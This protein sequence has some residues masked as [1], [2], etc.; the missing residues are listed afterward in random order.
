MLR[1]SG[2][3]DM[4]TF[5]DLIFTR[6]GYGMQ[7]YHGQETSPDRHTEDCNRTD[8]LMSMCKPKFLAALI[9]PSMLTEYHFLFILGL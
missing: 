6:G 8:V 1:K 7:A 2:Q 9:N 4:H 3:G 5:T